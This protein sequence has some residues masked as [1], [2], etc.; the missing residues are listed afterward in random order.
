VPTCALR[1]GRGE[2]A[3]QG[4][5]GVGGA[6]PSGWAGL[7]GRTG[8]FRWTNEIGPDCHTIPLVAEVGQE[9]VVSVSVLK[10]HR[11]AAPCS[12]GIGTQKVKYR[13]SQRQQLQR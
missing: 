4:S 12:A 1:P 2:G 3:T 7:S 5:E 6:Q 11:R 13:R 9:L 10:H 8:E